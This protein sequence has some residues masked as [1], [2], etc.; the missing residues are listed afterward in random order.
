M[1]LYSLG[2]GSSSIG[3]LAQSTQSHIPLSRQAFLPLPLPPRGLSSSCFPVRYCP[4][5]SFCW[6]LLPM[7][8]KQT[9]LGFS[10]Q[11]TKILNEP[12][13]MHEKESFPVAPELWLRF[14]SSYLS[15]KLEKPVSFIQV[16]ILCSLS[17]VLNQQ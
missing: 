4:R 17:L 13:L 15:P 5:A 16:I 11:V 3:N 10:P 9:L 8:P 6:I 14:C 2:P 7:A 1:G 12:F